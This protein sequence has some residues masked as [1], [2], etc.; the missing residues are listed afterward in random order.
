MGIKL[1]AVDRQFAQVGPGPLLVVLPHPDLCDSM[2]A[3]LAL[4]TKQA[5]T[6]FPAWEV[7]SEDL[8]LADELHGERIRLLKQLLAD[9]APRLI[10]TGMSALLQPV[11]VP[12]YCENGHALCALVSHSILLI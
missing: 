1:R 10:L 8:S 2:A 7:A 6:I 11:L 12:S 3:D 4:F 5:V 9:R